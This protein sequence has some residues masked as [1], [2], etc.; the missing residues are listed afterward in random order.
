[1]VSRREVAEK[2]RMAMSRKDKKGWDLE[3][4]LSVVGFVFEI[5]RVVVR[6]LQKRNGTVEHLRRLLKEPELVDKVFALIVGEET[7]YILLR[8]GESLVPVAYAAF[9]SFAELEKEFGKGNVSD[10]F[11]GRA[12]QKHASCMD[13]DETPGDRIF[14]VKHFNREIKSEDAIAEMDKPT[15]RRTRS[16]RPTPSCSVSSR[17]SPSARPR[18]TVSTVPSRCCAAAPAG[19]ASATAVSAAGGA[20]SAGSCSSASRPLDPRFL[21]P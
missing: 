8:A 3:A 12:F 11:D 13:I 7:G 16:P 6:A 15:S 19:A 20:P 21:G 18:R 17:S 14:L 10:L 1:M 4:L 9:P 5:M 2:R